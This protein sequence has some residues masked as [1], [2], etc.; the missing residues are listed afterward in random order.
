MIHF[1]RPLLLLLLLPWAALWVWFARHQRRS[2]EWIWRRVDQRFHHRFTLYRRRTLGRQM[3]L[4]LALGAL[5]VVAS[6]GPGMLGE[7]PVRVLSGRVVLL[8]DGSASMLADDVVG[9]EGKISRFELAREIGRELSERLEGS[10]LALVSFSGV[11]ALQLPMTGDPAAIDEALTALS[12]HAFYRSTG[13][14]FT[15]ALDAVIHFVEPP[16]A[17]LQAVLLSDGEQPFPEPFEE[18][19]AVLAERG[20]PVHAVAIGSREGQSRLIYDF[21][22]VV[23]GVEQ[24]RTLR[25]YHTRREERHLRRIA[26][27]TGG[28]FLVADATTAETLAEAVT[29]R[30]AEAE[31]VREEGRIDLGWLPLGLFLAGFL[32]E[33]LVWGRRR[34]VRPAAFDMARLAARPPRRLAGGLA[35]LAVVLPLSLAGCRPDTPASRAARENERGIAADALE[36]WQPARLHYERSRGYQVRPEIPSYNLARSVTLQGDFTE[37]HELYQAALELAPDLAPAHYNDGHA[38]FR[39]GAAEIDPA[40]CQLERTRELWD[41]ALLRFAGAAELYPEGSAGRDRS[42]RNL[43][44]LGARL[45]EIERLIADPPPHCRGQGGAGGGAGQA[46]SDGEEEREEGAREGG[47]ED[48][49]QDPAADGEQDDQEGGGAGGGGGEDD[50]QNANP[51][52]EEDTGG[53]GEPEGE[54]EDAERQEQEGEGGGGEG[55]EQE[56]EGGGEGQEGDQGQQAGGGVG[57][58]GEPLSGEELEQIRQAIERIAGERFADGRYHYRTLPEQF[59]PSVWQNPESEIWW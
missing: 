36:Q 16:S 12:F 22:D 46:E 31:W 29:E 57:A 26:G 34:A 41:A 15:A 37:A 7:A 24:P 9:R 40:G 13:S 8:V 33:A 27:R 32:L 59:P 43:R 49:E 14:S 42:R 51:D 2:C 30:L 3:L 5:L 1:E 48:E 10:R 19:L 20:V 4:L 45:A 6:A 35:A 23:A 56:G 18:P 54:G 58:G 38:L 52:E 21:N 39:W 47:G 28:R 44:E 25:E 11:A 17:D 50:P 55:E 53:E